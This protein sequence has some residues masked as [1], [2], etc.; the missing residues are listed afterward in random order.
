MASG[1]LWPSDRPTPSPLNS[2]GPTG[3]HDR[4]GD[5]LVCR[6]PGVARFVEGEDTAGAP[7]WPAQAFICAG[8]CPSL[9]PPG[10]LHPLARRSPHKVRRTSPRPMTAC[11]ELTAPGPRRLRAASVASPPGL[12]SGASSDPSECGVD[13]GGWDNPPHVLRTFG[14]NQT[15]SIGVGLS[16]ALGEF[17][18]SGSAARTPAS[19]TERHRV[20]TCTWARWLC[21]TPRPPLDRP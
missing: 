17:R 3:G 21:S 14:T 1:V 16:G 9:D 20:R 19:C 10:A 11:T 6:L 8:V 15:F 4:S 5:R 7:C 13:D 12:V 18:C 2:G